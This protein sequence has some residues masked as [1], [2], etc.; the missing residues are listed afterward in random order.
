LAN[1]EQPTKFQDSSFAGFYIGVN[2]GYGWSANTSD[3]TYYGMA[4]D[5]PFL[6]NRDQGFDAKGGFGGIQI[7]YNLQRDRLVFGIEGDFEL[8]GIKDRFTQIVG[9]AFDFER[10]TFRGKMKVNL[11]YSPYSI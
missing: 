9:P 7:G 4:P 8:S 6:V 10:D 5:G 1:K 11:F 3:I 2:G